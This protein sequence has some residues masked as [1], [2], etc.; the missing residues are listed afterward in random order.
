MEIYNVSLTEHIKSLFNN[1][2]YS[3][4]TFIIGS[5]KY[6]AHKPV[7]SQL[8]YFRTYFESMVGG[9]KKEMVLPNKAVFD[10]GIRYLYNSDSPAF[11]KGSENLVHNNLLTI[12]V[13]NFIEFY[14]QILI[15]E[16]PLTKNALVS[17]NWNFKNV[18]DSIF[19]I[20]YRRFAVEMIDR[21]WEFVASI[22][23]LYAK[24]VARSFEEK[25]YM[26]DKEI[27]ERDIF[28]YF[29]DKY[30]SKLFADWE[31]QEE[32][33]KLDGID[34]E[35][36]VAICLQ[37]KKPNM[38]LKIEDHKPT[39]K[40][41]IDNFH[42]N[43]RQ[44]SVLLRDHFDVVTLSPLVLMNK[45]CIGTVI[46]KSKKYHSVFVKVN[47]ETCC[48]K[49]DKIYFFNYG[50]LSK[51]HKINTCHHNGQILYGLYQELEY[52]IGFGEKDD[53]YPEYGSEVWILKE[54]H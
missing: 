10:F 4:F 51:N 49:T 8:G 15:W 5:E 39:A 43:P 18:T 41:I 42:P 32:I 46:G 45:V 9:E 22:G 12:S 19:N 23:D 40:F 7:L 47:V 24:D 16:H 37:I 44:K 20:Y 11:C 13:T 29:S 36:K 14:K 31:M 34:S 52:S 50:T 48:S 54:I 38:I 27:M 28:K 30:K 26:I 53:P 35:V 17:H 25:G 21:D 2:N 33:L 3:D 1:A 6:P